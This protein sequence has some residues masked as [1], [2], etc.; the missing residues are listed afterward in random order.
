MQEWFLSKGKKYAKMYPKQPDGKQ[1]TFMSN[2]LINEEDVMRLSENPNV[3]SVSKRCIVFTPEFKRKAYEELCSGR[4]INEILIRYGID[5][6]ALGKVRV[7]GFKEKIE[8]SAKRPEGF[9]N[10][11]KSRNTAAETEN[12]EASLQKQIR[13]LKQELAYTRQEVEFLKKIQM[14]DLEAQKKWESKH[15][16]K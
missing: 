11:R 16:Q 15:Q 8:I 7:R 14:A 1:G 2:F 12:T 10:L 9:T 3:E 13:E 4:K 5:P 6:E